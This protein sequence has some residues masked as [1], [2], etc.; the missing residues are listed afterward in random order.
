MVDNSDEQQNVQKQ[1]L[2]SQKSIDV[3]NEK[4][5]VESVSSLI[6]QY[7]H[8]VDMHDKVVERR[9]QT[10]SFYLSLLSGSLAFISILTSE[11]TLPQSKDI[12]PLL[13]VFV[14]SSLGLVL[15]FLW[16]WN[17]HGYA[18]L[19]SRKIKVIHEMEKYL[20]FYSYRREAALWKEEMQSKKAFLIPKSLKIA[21][22]EQFV[23]IAFG[24]VFITLIGYSIVGLSR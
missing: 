15:C 20:P 18:T 3:L 10:N 5:K 2:N 8:Y 9:G 1:D 21:T 11:E 16:Y 4:Y 24:V 22:I 19:I 14:V 13:I 7:K 12:D 6:E 17:I 23:S